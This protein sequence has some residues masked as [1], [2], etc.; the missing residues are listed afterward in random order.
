MQTPT[1]ND[2]PTA[3]KTFNWI[4]GAATV[5]AAIAIVA[6]T[7]LKVM[8]TAGCTTSDCP[9]LSEISFTLLQFGVP[10]VAVLTVVASFFTAR[11]RHGVWVP[12]IA[13]VLLILAAA[14]LFFGFR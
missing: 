7:Y 4:F 9:T 5:P 12:I 11:R 14:L 8:G 10:A 13:W 6:L 1:P 3:R 2:H